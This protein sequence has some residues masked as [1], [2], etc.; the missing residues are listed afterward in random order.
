[1]P[2]NDEI[3]NKIAMESESIKRKIDQKG[4]NSSALGLGV[5]LGIAI[6]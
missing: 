3:K 6:S 4:G 5:L 2:K 1:L